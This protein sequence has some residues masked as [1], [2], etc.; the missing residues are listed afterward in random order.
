MKNEKYFISVGEPWD[1]ENQEGQNII[2]GNILNVKSNQCLVF[3]SNHN[4]AIAMDVAIYEKGKYLSKGS[5]KQYNTYDSIAKER[6]R[7]RLEIFF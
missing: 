2:K 5:E 3:K 1:F 4:F 7:R 6:G